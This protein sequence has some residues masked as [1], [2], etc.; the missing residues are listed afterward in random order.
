MTQ[1]SMLVDKNQTIIIKAGASVTVRG[2]EGDLVS[3][4][5]K[6]RWGLTIQRKSEAEFARARAAIGERVLFDLHL[7]KPNFS[8]GDGEGMMVDDEVIEIQLGGSGEVQVPYGSTLKVY[9]GLNVDVQGVRGQVSAYAGLNLAMQDVYAL[10]NASAGR[11]MAIDCQTLPADSAEFTAGS[12]MRFHVIGLTSVKLRVKDLGGYWEARIGGGEKS[13]Y[14]KSGG[15]VTFVTGEQVDAL[16]PDF[17][18]G[19]IERPVEP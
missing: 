14:L 2:R 6:G 9:G 11:T 17:I 4:E 15:D 13:L 1:R 10:G 8:K 18:L 12:D 7:K 3:A 5:T 19:K 16:P